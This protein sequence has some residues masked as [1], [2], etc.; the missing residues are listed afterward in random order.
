MRWQQQVTARNDRRINNCRNS[1]GD[2]P[3]F[4][5]HRCAAVPGKSGQSPTYSF[6]NLEE[7]LALRVDKPGEARAACSTMGQGDLFAG[8]G[9]LERIEGVTLP[10][11]AIVPAPA[12]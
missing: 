10:A 9:P 1:Q 7:A 5:D 2:S 4:A 11:E 12:N 3:I 8:Q 6:A